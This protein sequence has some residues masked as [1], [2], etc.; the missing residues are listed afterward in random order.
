MGLILNA[1]RTREF[2]FNQWRH[3]NWVKWRS[4]TDVTVVA[5]I[6]S[7][8]ISPGLP[9]RLAQVLYWGGTWGW[10]P[11][12]SP[13]RT[14]RADW[15]G[16]RQSRRFAALNWLKPADTPSIVFRHLPPKEDCG[17]N[18]QCLESEW[19]RL[20]CSKRLN[21]Y[22][23]LAGGS[24]EE[25]R[26]PGVWWSDAIDRPARLQRRRRQAVLTRYILHAMYYWH[27]MYYT[28]RYYWHVTYY[29]PCTTDTLCT[30]RHVLLTRYVLHA[31][32]YWHVMYYTPCTTDTL[33]TT[34]HV[35]LTQWGR[36]SIDSLWS[37]AD[38]LRPSWRGGHHWAPTS[39]PTPTPF[40]FP[41][42]DQ[43]DR[44]TAVAELPTIFQDA[45]GPPTRR[46]KR[47]TPPS[48]RSSSAGPRRSGSGGGKSWYSSPGSALYTDTVLFRYSFH[49]LL[50]KVQMAWGRY[51]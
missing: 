15:H 49:P 22:Q 29:T 32:Y 31:M 9:A 45:R 2:V 8:A 28:L 6:H 51:S 24:S 44:R 27:V 12:P 20:T 38:G 21:Q 37:R 23:Q 42:Q 10:A 35:L 47:L 17:V 13:A 46:A 5:G 48:L 40:P 41:L 14:G 3:W 11:W 34:R 36:S 19:R 4:V 39:Y 33:C 18:P 7:L 43:H 1:V 26:L 30:T 50:P 16:C 25:L